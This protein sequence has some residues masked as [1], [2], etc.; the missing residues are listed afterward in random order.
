[1]NNAT[2]GFFVGVHG[3]SG[4][5]WID[6]F[7]SQYGGLPVFFQHVNDNLRAIILELLHLKWQPLKVSPKIEAFLPN[8]KQ[9][10]EVMCVASTSAMT[11]HVDSVVWRDNIRLFSHNCRQKRPDRPQ[12]WV[13]LVISSICF[14]PSS[15]QVA[16]NNFVC[17]PFQP[18]ASPIHR[19]TFKGGVFWCTISSDAKEVTP[20]LLSILNQYQY[21]YSSHD[22]TGG[23]LASENTLK[24]LHW[25]ILIF[26]K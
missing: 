21:I 13:I 16:K 10:E 19:H 14:P 8:E 17:K 12:S 4:P 20:P 2:L 25:T 11:P 26:C 15:H 6:L 7:P 3:P 24:S 22:F 18:R 1:M 5:M 9:M 23:T